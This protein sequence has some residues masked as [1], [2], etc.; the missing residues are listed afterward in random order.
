MLI[1]ENKEQKLIN[2]LKF[3]GSPFKKFVST[4]EIKEDIGL[5]PSRQ[6]FLQ[7]IIAII[8]QNENFIL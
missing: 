3:I 6:E 2:V 1:F 5:V 7:D 4:G 8:K